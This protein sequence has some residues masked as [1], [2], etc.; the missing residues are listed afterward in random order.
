MKNIL[1]IDIGNTRTKWGVHDGCAWIEQGAVETLQISAF[2]E[3]LKNNKNINIINK[4][5]ISSV[6]DK[7][8]AQALIKQLQFADAEIISVEPRAQQCGVI[9]HYDTP[10][11]LG[12]DRWCALIASHQL[13]QGHALVVMA[14]TA[15]TVDALTADGH[16]LGGMIVP[17]L[18]LMQDSLR[19]R[20]AQ[21]RPEVGAYQA[22]PTHTQDA[23]HSGIISASL[24]AIANA[25]AAMQAAGHSHPTCIISGGGASWLAPHLA[26]PVMRIDNLV[27]EG[28]L[29]IAQAES[30]GSK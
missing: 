2:A 7:S 9:N 30:A 15:M 21:L 19:T 29:H 14:G 26:E 27:L 13:H 25:R 20:T 17:G 1:A 28:L 16:F 24:G 10:W 8:I 11:Q 6:A 23:I 12:S 5:A 4:I 18:S 3:Q 22:F